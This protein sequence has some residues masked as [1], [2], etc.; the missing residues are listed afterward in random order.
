MVMIE[1]WADL[2]IAAAAERIGSGLLSPSEWVAACLR[3]AKNA[4]THLHAFV[5][6]APEEALA[7]AARAGA[8]IAG[9]AYRGPLHGAPLALK[10]V[11]DVAGMPCTGNSA[12]FRERM[13]EA[14]A[15][16]SEALR[17]AGGVIL[18]KLAAW[19]FALG[20]TS[21]ALPWPPA[22]NPWNLE[23]DPG[24]SSSGSAAAVA[25]GLCAGALGTD[26]GGSIREPASWCGIA[27]LKPSFGLVGRRG[28][29]AVSPTLDHVG[30]M[31]WTSED[32][33]LMLDALA[34]PGEGTPGT[35]GAFSR[36]IGGSVSGLRVGLVDLDREEH[37]SLGGAI[38]ASVR[39]AAALLGRLGARVRRVE[40]AR[41]EL[42]SAVVTIIAAAEAFAIHQP[43]LALPCAG[44]DGITRARLQSGAEVTGAAYFLATGMR[45]QL[46]ARCAEVMRSVDILIMP[47]TADAAPPLGEVNSHAGH[48]SLTRPW[49]AT[50][51]PALSICSGFS[52]DGLPL[53][54]QIIG[55]PLED[56]LVL[57]VGHALEIALGSRAVRRPGVN[58]RF[59]NAEP[60][61]V[62][63]PLQSE[64]QALAQGIAAA[65]E[66]L[67]SHA[68]SGPWDMGS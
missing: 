31:A 55:R 40:L 61:R 23:R 30:P 4:A 41:L 8:E 11:I 24:G 1:D 68:Q 27:G 20:T 38:D 3:R 29:M 36:E 57:R 32:C 5:H 33:A 37:L 66:L 62:V 21:F 26:T 50:G 12:L 35:A 52:A 49:N 15:A 6:I 51:Q 67:A 19:E 63:A 39:E 16:A 18:G 53:A 7:D 59:P 43:T 47:T 54:L 25:A 34:R 9:G 56:G 17:R 46:A 22:R 65:A 28:I 42:F 64:A 14:D 2:T 13:P 58:S 44:L 60:L 45:S 10:D 48:P